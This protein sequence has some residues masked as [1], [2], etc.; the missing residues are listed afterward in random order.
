[1][2]GTALARIPTEDAGGALAVGARGERWPFEG[3]TAERATV[4]AAA[5]GTGATIVGSAGVGKTRLVTE[6]LSGIDAQ[7]YA[8]MWVFGTAAMSA[9]SLGAFAAFGSPG[10]PDADAVAA[11]VGKVRAHAAGRRPVLVVDDAHLL[12][13][14]SI[15]VVEQLVLHHGGSFVLTARA[16][17]SREL[18][19]RLSTVDGSVLVDLGELARPEVVRIVERV[20]EAPANRAL[21]KRIWA[22]TGGNPLLL[23]VLV[24][25]A[26][27]SGAIRRPNGT[28][29]WTGPIVVNQQLADVVNAQLGSRS[30]QERRLLELL[31]FGEP[32]ALDVIATLAGGDVI[33][34]LESLDLVRVDGSGEDARVWLGHPIYGEVL[35][36]E[37][38]RL[39]SARLLG[40]L[41]DAVGT[42]TASPG[43]RL[44]AAVWL[45]DSD[46]TAPAEFWL[47]AAREAWRR[48]DPLLT[49]R[50][51]TR[52]MA[53]G[54]TPAVLE[55]LVGSLIHDGRSG[56]ADELLADLRH[57][58]DDRQRP[59]LDFLGAFRL[60]FGLGDS[61]R[62]SELLT[63]PLA[64]ADAS[65][66]DR[67]AL[68]ECHVRACG[69]RTQ[70]ALDAV[71]AL[72]DRPDVADSIRHGALAVRAQM[73]M[74]RG[75]RREARQ[76]ADA[77]RERALPDTETA[78]VPI[79]MYLDWID[80]DIRMA[81][82][83]FAEVEAAMERQLDAV[84]RWTLGVELYAALAAAAARQ[85]GRLSDALRW[86]RSGARV[87]P[88]DQ[89]TSATCMALAELAHTNALL[90]NH[91]HA[92]K[93][94]ALAEACSRPGWQ[95]PGFAVELA[96]PWVVASSGDV[97]TAIELA[98][99]FAGRAAALEAWH[100][101]AIALH[102]A[103]R[104]G[105]A[106][107]V[108]TRLEE[109]ATSMDGPDVPL[110][111]AHARALADS[112]AAGLERVGQDFE[113]AGLLLY[114]AEATARAAEHHDRAGLDRRAEL[115]RGQAS[116]LVAQC[117]GARTPALAGLRM[118][119][120]TARERQIAELAMS[121]LTNPQIA[122]RLHLSRR[123]VENR[124][125][126]IY[127][128]L[129]ISSRD[130]LRD[131]G[132]LEIPEISE[133]SELEYGSLYRRA[134]ADD[135]SA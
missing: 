54:A 23:R 110:Y 36:A 91:R 29:I 71:D 60:H 64:A 66:R 35:R 69:G 21:H 128:K 3:R 89:F 88:S 75:R 43:D 83:E 5:Q 92:A 126:A 46:A 17:C 67:A 63:G 123:T 50:M 1:M 32:L 87:E 33:E 130:E 94:L 19:T 135:D 100:V 11:L 82:L 65:L 113:R 28:C 62:A 8:V 97:R 121:G 77:L 52:A 20:L 122:L 41:A 74:L 105:A 115:A 78:D 44:R 16:D 4:L 129:G 93:D 9:V 102:D 25:A 26:I 127:T 96:R 101:E 55:A 34:A 57:R 48:F 108:C 10:A 114:A 53:L 103:A 90:G 99:E 72:L 31:A 68:L 27:A 81:D 61:G 49:Q 42:D 59:L 104:L 24:Q 125:Y 22:A 7:R 134:A 6:A 30:D 2:T 37:C 116:R 106:A 80:A 70:A 112:D 119:E 45:L 98:V 117:Q 51:A 132:I 14:V 13:A 58:A 40:E 118:P 76:I 95:Y 124:L 73:L 107:A 86:S 15:A 47:D 133:T 56:Q 38:R 109:L 79:G 84:Q 85:R 111:A 131:S 39:R 120:L 12:D 18:L